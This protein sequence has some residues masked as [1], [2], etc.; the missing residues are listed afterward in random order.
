L[1]QVLDATLNAT[2]ASASES[3]GLAALRAVAQAL[4]GQ[5]FGL[6][7]AVELISAV[8][9]G[10]FS[11]REIATEALRPVANRVAATLCDDPVSRAR[12]E[13]LWERLCERSG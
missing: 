3:E 7:V 10:Q 2:A 4:P 9:A 6:T 12:L 8:L 11:Q 13:A 5:P 1:K